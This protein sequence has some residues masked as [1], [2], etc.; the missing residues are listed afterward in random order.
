MTY[1]NVKTGE[2]ITTSTKATGRNWEPVEEQPQMPPVDDI[3]E[4][5]IVDDIPE[6]DISEEETPVEKPVKSA[7]K[8]KK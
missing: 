2:I 7:R 5:D 6:D 3:P 1:R 8:G 4:D